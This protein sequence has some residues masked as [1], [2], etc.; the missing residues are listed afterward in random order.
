MSKQKPN[1]RLVPELVPSPLW[2]KSVHKTIKRSQWDREIRKKVLDQANNICA[3]CGASYE[4]GMICHEEWEYVDD[5]HIARL[6]GFRLICRDCNFV[7]HYDKAGTLGRAEDA[8]LHLSKV[9]QI[10]EEA[11]KAIISASIDKWIE[12]SSIEDWKIEI[13]PKL[14]AEYP[15]LHDVDLS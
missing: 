11:A 14:I 15:I 10:K 2:G 3:T 7:N 13:S 4:K 1:P 9:N 8:L 5:A 6:I 12:R